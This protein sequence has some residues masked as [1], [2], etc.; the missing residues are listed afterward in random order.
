MKDQI[1]A[2]EKYWIKN[3]CKKALLNLHKQFPLMKNDK[4]ITEI[5]V[6]VITCLR[7]KF[8]MNLPSSLLKFWSLPSEAREISKLQKMNEV[9]FPQISWINMWFPV[10]LMLQAHKGKNTNNQYQQI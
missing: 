8:G 6:L 2:P 7:G 5:L 4:D 1:H 10:N 3:S 9:N